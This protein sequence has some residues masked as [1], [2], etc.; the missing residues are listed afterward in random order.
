MCAARLE[1]AMDDLLF[2]LLTL[3]FFALAVLAVK[4]VERL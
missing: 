1:P 3:A 2:V 4:A